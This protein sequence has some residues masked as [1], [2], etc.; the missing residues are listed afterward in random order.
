MLDWSL[1]DLTG[2]FLNDGNVPIRRKFVGR[3]I[4]IFSMSDASAV[5]YHAKVIIS[6]FSS[7][8]VVIIL[9]R[10]IYDSIYILEAHP[11]DCYVLE[12]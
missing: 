1:K 8:S 3:L 4:A 6:S 11:P 7:V 9:L 5:I 2:L 10:T 12:F